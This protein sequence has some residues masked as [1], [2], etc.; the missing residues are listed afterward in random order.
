MILMMAA[1]AGKKKELPTADVAVS[2]QQ[3]A[4]ADRQRQ[5]GNFEG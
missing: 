3:Q 4:A 5:A 1:R 2:Q